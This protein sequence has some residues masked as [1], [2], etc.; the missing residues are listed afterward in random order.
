MDD[1]T[2]FFTRF[3]TGLLGVEIDVPNGC[4]AGA[5]LREARIEE[6]ERRILAI[7]A[8]LQSLTP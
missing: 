4:D 1:R 6:I 8:Q 5:L 7:E 3:R 2:L